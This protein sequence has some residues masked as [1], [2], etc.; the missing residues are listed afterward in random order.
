MHPQS[1][2]SKNFWSEWFKLCQNA[3]ATV[4]ETE[5]GMQKRISVGLGL[6]PSGNLNVAAVRPRVRW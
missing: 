6:L 5:E 1:L 4:E 3:F 2:S